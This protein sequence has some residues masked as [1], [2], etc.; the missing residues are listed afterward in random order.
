MSLFEIIML[1]CFGLAWL[2][3]IYQ[4]CTARRKEGKSVIFL[5]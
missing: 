1:I 3:S 2:F 4:T 5:M